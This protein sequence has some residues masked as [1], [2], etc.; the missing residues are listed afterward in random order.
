V[1]VLG[2]HPLFATRADTGEVLHAR[3][4]KGL[5]NT[6]RGAKRFV[7]DLVA[8]LRRAGTPDEIALR[9]DSGFWSKETM[10]SLR[11]L[12]VRFTMAVRANTKAFS[13]AIEAVAEDAWSAFDY[14]EGGEAQVAETTYGGLRLV[15]RRTRQVGPIAMRAAVFPLLR[16]L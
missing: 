11:R 4:R 7:E 5:A 13:R 6:Q 8:R 10:G 2:Q 3:M 9:M 12:G 16:R 14:P 1:Q 15:V